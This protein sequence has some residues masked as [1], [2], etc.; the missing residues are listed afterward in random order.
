MGNHHL[1]PQATF[2]WSSGNLLELEMCPKNFINVVCWSDVFTTSVSIL[3]SKT[4]DMHVGAQR[5]S[6]ADRNSTAVSD[7]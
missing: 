2:S 4:S 3:K 5:K 1:V 7:S 6:V